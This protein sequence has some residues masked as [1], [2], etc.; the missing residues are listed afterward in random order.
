M[1]SGTLR[2]ERTRARRTRLM[3]MTLN[4][5]GLCRRPASCGIFVGSVMAG[6]GTIIPGDI[7]APPATEHRYGPAGARVVQL[8]N[9]H[10]TA[11]ETSPAARQRCCCAVDVG[12]AVGRTAAAWFGSTA[13]RGLI[14]QP[15]AHA[16]RGRGNIFACSILMLFTSL[17]RGALCAIMLTQFQAAV[18]TGWPNLLHRAAFLQAGRPAPRQSQT[19]SP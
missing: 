12:H 13:E 1:P 18:W 4:Y 2:S 6:T 17:F 5:S 7:P 19:L 11:P 9:A 3:P 15:M 8:G 16:T 14:A 10:L